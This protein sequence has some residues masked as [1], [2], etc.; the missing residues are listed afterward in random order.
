MSAER[1]T[2]A[3]G[4]KISF[5]EGVFIT[6]TIYGI[7]L[8]IYGLSHLSSIFSAS[9]GAGEKFWWIAKGLSIIVVIFVIF[10]GVKKYRGAGK[11]SKV[12]TTEDVED[13]SFL[14]PLILGL[15]WPGLPVLFVL[16]LIVYTFAPILL[17]EPNLIMLL[18][19]AI[20]LHVA[21][22]SAMR[23]SIQ[24]GKKKSH[25]G[26]T[27][28]S[29]VMGK[30]LL[31][32]IIGTLAYYAYNPD[33]MTSLLKRSELSGPGKA[34]VKHMADKERL[35]QSVDEDDL[36]KNT[37]VDPGFSTSEAGKWVAILNLWNTHIAND[38]IKNG[39]L[40]PA[41][42]DAAK[43]NPLQL[44]AGSHIS[45]DVILSVTNSTGTLR[46]GVLL[47][48]GECL[49]PTRDRDSGHY[50]LKTCTG[51]WKT[52]SNSIMGVYALVF[53]NTGRRFTVDLYEGNF[54]KSAPDMKLTVYAKD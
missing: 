45:S 42:L 46:D 23:R 51:N 36:P 37:L 53:N 44:G 40:S 24:R 39:R 19:V 48:N 22:R 27:F 54:I 7:F 29:S 16:G 17:K 11:E 28:T 18:I 50:T 30:V 41:L 52:H 1:N 43:G 38:G 20:A 8:L 21:L 12:V 31:L 49:S 34:F 15:I 9:T 47:Y 26:L 10:R 6:L 4:R 13:S 33:S 32:S 25:K 2:I 3:T 14:Q 5:W 35:G